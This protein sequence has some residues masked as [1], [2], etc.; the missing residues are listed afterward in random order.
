MNTNTHKQP[1]A[2]A[3]ESAQSRPIAAVRARRYALQVSE[4]E[5]K[6]DATTSTARP[7]YAEGSNSQQR[8]LRRFHSEEA[9][10]LESPTSLV[11]QQQTP[12]ARTGGP[13][14]AFSRAAPQHIG[15][16][17]KQ[18]SETAAFSKHQNFKTQNVS[19]ITGELRRE[20]SRAAFRPAPPPTSS[21]A[22]Q[23]MRQLSQRPSQQ[24]PQ[25]QQQEQY[26]P[27]KQG[28]Q[29]SAAVNNVHGF[30][31]TSSSSTAKVDSAFGKPS[32]NAGTISPAPAR[33]TGST[34]TLPSPVAEPTG[35]K[36]SSLRASRIPRLAVSAL[37]SDGPDISTRLL[38]QEIQDKDQRLH[39][40]QKANDELI[41]EVKEMASIT[42]ALNSK[43][44]KAQ[45]E[46]EEATNRAEEA[47]Q[48][49][50]EQ[51]MEISTLKRKIEALSGVIYAQT[52]ACGEGASLPSPDRSLGVS[53]GLA[54]H[55]LE[56]TEHTADWC[57]E[58]GKQHQNHNHNMRTEHTQMLAKI[59]MIHAQC[60]MAKPES[61]MDGSAV[62]DLELVERYVMNSAD[63]DLNSAALEVPED[64]FSS[65]NLFSPSKQR[66]A[67][68][69]NNNADEAYLPASPR[70]DT[71]RQQLR[72]TEQ[73]EER[74]MR[75]RSTMLFAGLIKPSTGL[76]S[77][78]L[79]NAH[80]ASHQLPTSAACDDYEQQRRRQQCERCLQLEDALQALET[81]NDYYREANKKLRNCVT[82]AVSR[83]NALIRI[84]E[85]ERARRLEARASALAKAS[86]V[87]ARNRAQLEAQQRAEINGAMSDSGGGRSGPVPALEAAC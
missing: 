57:P 50:G 42:E 38:L 59:G 24:K 27:Y 51:Q 43:L 44:E 66:R 18:R 80:T 52:S 15:S 9:S 47:E 81:D 39:A 31:T 84:F 45:A 8:G 78:Y 19:A 2:T 73:E 83:H 70:M 87:A 60:T 53:F 64:T 68:R 16:T 56:D 25:Q 10:R 17:G 76:S 71:H 74:E 34:R 46:A 11:Q 62:R 29:S 28:M 23:Q 33:N 58:E 12:P 41:Q 86:Q 6:A 36:S 54:T 3:K 65:S 67:L 82:D 14:T 40:E 69:R 32:R 61:E 22:Y 63:E 20:L 37:S 4:K 49:V 85:R 75:R 13:A 79:A 55:H 7:A 77:A 1:L 26:Q 35:Y 72:T 21:A 48:R 5:R 30:R